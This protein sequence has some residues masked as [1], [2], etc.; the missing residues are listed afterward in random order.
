[1]QEKLNKGFKISYIINSCTFLIVIFLLINMFMTN[2]GNL[3]EDLAVGFVYVGLYLLNFLVSIILFVITTILG[4]KNFKKVKK[5]DT[6][7]KIT[8]MMSLLGLAHFA[9]L[10]FTIITIILV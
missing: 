7:K 1:M 10:L 6:K 4:V 2:S 5:E 3:L 9:I 8:L